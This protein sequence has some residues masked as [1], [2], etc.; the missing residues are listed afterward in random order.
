MI[1]RDQEPL[2]LRRELISF[3]LEYEAQMFQCRFSCPS[4]ALFLPALP[5][6]VKLPLAA[7]TTAA[8]NDGIF[9][10]VKM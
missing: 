9:I 6:P 3:L 4:L 1:L 2:Y 10:L 5:F 8:N 7:A